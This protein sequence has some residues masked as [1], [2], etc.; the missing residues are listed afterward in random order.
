[1]SYCRW[2]ECDVY[3][4]DSCEGG[5]RFWVAGDDS[6]NRLCGTHNEA[7]Q[8]AKRLRDEHGFDVPLHAIDELREDAIDEAKGYFGPDSAVAELISK[9]A[10]LLELVD[11]LRYCANESHGHGRCSVRFV[12]GYVT[13]CPLY[14]VDSDTARCEALLRELG[15]EVDA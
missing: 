15:V 5:V 9:N 10:K 12:D 11:G 13:Y 14:D 7:Y 3:A 2:S 6:F 8:Y 4:Y 1:M